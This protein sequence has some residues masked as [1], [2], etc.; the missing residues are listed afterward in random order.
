MGEQTT[1]QEACDEA[2]YRELV[3]D[4]MRAEAMDNMRAERDAFYEPFYQEY[5]QHCE[6]E[7]DK[8]PMDFEEFVKD[9][10]LAEQQYNEDRQYFYH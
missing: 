5:L 2:A 3:E 6:G 10:D 9:F 4:E 7:G 1:I 8:N